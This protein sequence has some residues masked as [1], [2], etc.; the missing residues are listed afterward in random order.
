MVIL[1]CDL[2]TN[3]AQLCKELRFCERTKRAAIHVVCNLFK[4]KGAFGNPE[5][6][7]QRLSV[8]FPRHAN[9]NMSEL[10]NQLKHLAVDPILSK[11]QVKGNKKSSLLFSGKESA[12]LD[13]ETV[14]EIGV[15]GLQELS[16]VSVMEGL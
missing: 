15:Q 16:Q 1:R 3:F 11:Q 9:N 13:V 10:A 8:R 5:F 4:K 14:R 6:N 12:K 7:P 2:I